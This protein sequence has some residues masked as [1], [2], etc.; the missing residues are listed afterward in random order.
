MYMP[1]RATG[2]RVWCARNLFS[3]FERKIGDLMPSLRQ[4]AKFRILGHA[5][6]FDQTIV[7]AWL[8]G[9]AQEALADHDGDGQASAYVRESTPGSVHRPPR[10]D[11]PTGLGRPDPCVA[12][13]MITKP[14]SLKRSASEYTISDELLGKG[15]YGYVYRASRVSST[16]GE[17]RL[18]VKRFKKDTSDD[19]I[20][21]EA[22]IL[23]RCRRNPHFV[24]LIDVFKDTSGYALVFEDGGSSLSDVLATAV[25]TPA[26]IR[27][28]AANINSA[29]AHLH[30]ILMIHCDVK[31]SN[32]LVATGDVWYCRLADVG[33][34]Y[35]ARPCKYLA[36]Q[37]H[38][39]DK[40][41]NRTYAHT[42][43][44][45]RKRMCQHAYIRTY[46]HAH[47]CVNFCAL[48]HLHTC[49]YVRAYVCTYA[50]T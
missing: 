42:Y 35:A 33:L 4:D 45:V 28:V 21:A 50:R 29:L 38:T 12:W 30:S 34:A 22:Y 18:A 25:I 32:I 14:K 13:K 8:V 41:N 24:Q 48:A 11:S 27:V 40:T 15:S 37:K 9:E 16:D 2:L 5:Q 43:V 7:D 1:R 31:P 3:R 10:N 49:T 46:V 6:D 36:W 20:L 26:Q 23:D 39:C 47:V 44:Y 19:D 17:A